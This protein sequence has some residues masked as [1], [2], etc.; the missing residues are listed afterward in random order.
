MPR[1][2]FILVRLLI[3]DR[4]LTSCLFTEAPHQGHPLGTYSLSTCNEGGIKFSFKPSPRQWHLCEGP[5]PCTGTCSLPGIWFAASPLWVSVR[6]DNRPCNREDGFIPRMPWFHSVAV[7]NCDKK[8][9]RETMCLFHLTLPDF[10]LSLREGW[11]SRRGHLL[12]H[13]GLPKIR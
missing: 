12:F 9:L 13:A 8:R 5:D 6:K 2:A 3:L 7:N 4:N 10:S 1:F 11:D